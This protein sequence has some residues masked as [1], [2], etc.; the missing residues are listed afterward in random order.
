MVLGTIFHTL[1]VDLMK[2]IKFRLTA[3]ILCIKLMNVHFTGSKMK[4]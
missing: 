1:G 4:K 3:T 2:Q